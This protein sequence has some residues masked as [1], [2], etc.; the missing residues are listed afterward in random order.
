MSMVSWSARAV[1]IGFGVALLLAGCGRARPRA[2]SVADTLAS[3]LPR[4]LARPLEPWLASWRRELPGL[5]LDSLV[6]QGEQRYAP[7]FAGKGA[8]WPDSSLRARAGI[9]V[10]SPDSTRALDVDMYMDFDVDSDGRVLVMHEPD[11][12][13]LLFDFARDTVWHVEFCGTCCGYETACWLDSTRFAL[14]G[15]TE[16][17]AVGDA[18]WQAFVDVYDLRAR[19]CDRWVSRPVPRDAFGRHTEFS[20]SLL[21]VRLVRAGL[22]THADHA[23]AQGAGMKE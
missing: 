11:S 4:V 21:G 3:G 13:P 15:G 6:R 18:P 10:I 16:T 2:G 8:G 22:T 12:T 7:Y 9:I 19:R 20:D 14:A 23:P 1:A 17:G 5:G